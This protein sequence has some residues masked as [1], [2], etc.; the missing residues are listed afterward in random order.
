[1]WIVNITT[2]RE[3]PRRNLFIKY[4]KWS[5]SLSFVVGDKQ[6]Q[7]ESFKGIKYVISML[8]LEKE[9]RYNLQTYCI[10]STLF[11]IKNVD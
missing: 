11:N 4:K 5:N 2:T 10:L 1:M 9:N 3:T 7:G 8:F 6:Y